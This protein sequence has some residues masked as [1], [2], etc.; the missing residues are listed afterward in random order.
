MILG[1]LRIGARSTTYAALKCFNPSHHQQNEEIAFVICWNVIKRQGDH[2]IQKNNEFVFKIGTCKKIQYN[3][4]R[5]IPPFRQY[6]KKRVFFHGR[7]EWQ[8]QAL[9]RLRS[10]ILG[11]CCLIFIIDSDFFFRQNCVS[12]V[13]AFVYCFSCV[14]VI[15]CHCTMISLST[16]SC[17]KSNKLRPILN[18]QFCHAISKNIVLNLF[19]SKQPREILVFVILKL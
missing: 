6:L 2:Y 8:G 10:D 15:L 18:G 5:G 3:L 9:I 4:G 11:G 19:G 17:L 7:T 12:P 13:W 14:F 16:R 1:Q